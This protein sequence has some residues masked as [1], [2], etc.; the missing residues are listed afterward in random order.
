MDINQFFDLF[1]QEINQNE[2]LSKYY[3]LYKN[4][5][6]FSFRK[7]Y[8]IQR[9]EYIYNQTL[10]AINELNAS[11]VKIWDCGCGYGTTALFFAMN[12]IKVNGTTIGLHYSSEIEKRKKYWSS[13][14]NVELFTVDFN[15]LFETPP[16]PSS[17]NIIIVQDVLHHLEPLEEALSIFNSSLKDKG[18]LII[19]EANGN[20][21]YHK[22]V[23]Y[24]RRKNNR[25]IEIYDELLKKNVLYGDEN[26][27]NKKTWTKVLKKHN[28]SLNDFEYIKLLPPFF[29]NSNNMEN[30]IDFEQKIWK[31]FPFIGEYFF[32]GM[33]F[34]ASIEKVLR[35]V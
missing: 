18:K 32:F 25:I 10:K 5:G 8:F 23:E 9:L 35:T 33:N 4:S 34:T 1:L 28:L 16:S 20:S 24:K 6:M 15:N 29:Y 30:I 3:K 22:L 27:K 12:G 7:A 11:D 14:G 31:N 17:C 19:A 13:Y 2:K 26:F 21:L